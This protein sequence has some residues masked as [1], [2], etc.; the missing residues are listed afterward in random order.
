MAL[1]III[2]VSGSGK[3]SLAKTMGEC[4]CEADSYPNLYKDGILVASLLSAAHQACI[5]SVEQFMMAGMDI[6]QSNTNLDLRSIKPYLELAKLYKYTVRL[7]LPKYD[8]LHYAI[9]DMSR[10][11]QLAALV[12]ARSQ[13]DKR[14]PFNVIQR[15]VTQYDT[16]YPILSKMASETD[17]VK[18]LAYCK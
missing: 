13:G 17:P 2:G 18:L 7:I 11:A 16:L 8:L 12:N 1:C 4:I 6:I 10:P 3:S 15:M 9:I 5:D 14:V